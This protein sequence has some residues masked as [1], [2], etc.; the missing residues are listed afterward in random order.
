YPQG[1]DPNAGAGYPQVPPPQ[2]PPPV[3]GAGTGPARPEVVNPF[4]EQSNAIPRTGV[5]RAVYRATFGAVNLG[6]SEEERAARERRQRVVRPLHG[7]W[8]VV[9][10]SIK[11][12]VGKTTTAAMLGRTLAEWRGDRVVALDT[13]PDMGTLGDRLVGATDVT[14]RGLLAHEARAPIQQV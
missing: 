1:G 13:N 12:G 8:R 9:V 2:V 5:R 11:G 6:P 7:S 4:L 14:V 10:M 3:Q